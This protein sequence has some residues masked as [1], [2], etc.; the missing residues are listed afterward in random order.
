MAR[1]GVSV[2]VGALVLSCASARPTSKA[3]PPQGLE[4]IWTD[5]SSGGFP[6]RVVNRGEHFEYY[7]TTENTMVLWWK[8]TREVVSSW[9][10]DAGNQWY[11]TNDTATW[12]HCG[13]HSGQFACSPV[14]GKWQLLHKVSD[15][16]MKLEF[17][18][19]R[20]DEFNPDR[21]AT[22]INPES[23][24]LALAAAYRVFKRAE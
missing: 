20:V 6:G 19:V 2:L 9:T 10:D 7:D 8:G 24:D 4:G 11:K 16:G 22:D 3:G 12:N 23:G 5:A 18:F 14:G 13:A 15:S 21:F 17:V 1:I